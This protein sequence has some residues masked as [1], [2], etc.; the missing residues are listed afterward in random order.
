MLTKE[1]FVRQIKSLGIQENDI[2]YIR[3][4]LGALGKVD[5][6]LFDVIVNGLKEAVGPQ[7]TILAPAFNKIQNIFE[8]KKNLISLDTI[9][10]SG[11]VSKLFLKHPEMKRSSHPSHSFVAIGPKALDLL[12][13]HD[14]SAACFLPIKH[15]AEMNGKM[16][17]M[18][19]VNES[20]GFSTV[21]VAQFELGL[22][23]KHF[24][25]YLQRGWIQ[26]ENII[27]KWLP[28]ESPG[29]SLSFG[30]FYLSYIEDKN[31]I[32]GWIGSAYTLVVP[33]ARNALRTELDLLKGHPTFVDCGRADCLTCGMRGY[34]LLRIPKTIV[35]LFLKKIFGKR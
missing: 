3:A 26:K 27:K 35:A 1:E 8:K 33:S 24:V 5:G 30:K 4:S 16:I 28:I 25:R 17:L 29:C 20:P 13:G 19:C 15:L 6:D 23:Q 10:I 11:A 21:H 18:G 9:P 2:V 32:S 14:E 7:G 12:S 31:L 34:E 22:S